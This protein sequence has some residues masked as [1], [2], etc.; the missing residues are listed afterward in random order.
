MDVEECVAWTNIPHG[1][2]YSEPLKGSN[3]KGMTAWFDRYVFADKGYKV[4]G[5]FSTNNIR[6][7][8]LDPNDIYDQM[9][10]RMDEHR[11]N[12]EDSE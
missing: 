8:P 11:H 1:R 3:P 7:V 10:I 5:C 12:Y 2:I 9:I 4:L 6:C